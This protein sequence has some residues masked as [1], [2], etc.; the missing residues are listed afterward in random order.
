MTVLQSSMEDRKKLV[1]RARQ[2]ASDIFPLFRNSIS[3]TFYVPVNTEKIVAIHH[4]PLKQQLPKSSFL[5]Q[6]I[7]YMRSTVFF[8]ITSISNSM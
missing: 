4:P 3:P 7:S 2:I 5:S 1:A 6:W 8:T